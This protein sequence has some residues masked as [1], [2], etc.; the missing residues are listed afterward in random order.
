METH[1]HDPLSQWWQAVTYRDRL[2]VRRTFHW[3]NSAQAITT[4]SIGLSFESYRQTLSASISPTAA[5]LVTNCD[6][7]L[8]SRRQSVAYKGHGFAG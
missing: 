5:E 1:N 4:S 3:L 8:T 6:H 7:P 2:Y